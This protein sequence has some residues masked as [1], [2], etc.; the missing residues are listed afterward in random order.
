MS[1]SVWQL[2]GSADGVV[3]GGGGDWAVRDNFFRY[4][5]SS[6]LVIKNA[7]THLEVC[8]AGNRGPLK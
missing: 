3:E 2:L 5:R 1:V 6:P 4:P 7:A 8:K